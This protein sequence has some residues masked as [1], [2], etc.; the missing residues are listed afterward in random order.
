[1]GWEIRTHDVGQA[2]SHLLITPKGS[3][4]LL[5]ADEDRIVNSLDIRTINHFISTHL[6]KDHIAGLRHLND[7]GYSIDQAYQPRAD[8]Y[9]TDIDGGVKTDVLNEYIGN[10]SSQ[11]IE[12]EDINYLT[13]GDEILQEEDATLTALSPPETDEEIETTSQSSGYDCL[14]KPEE[15]NANGTV[16]KFEGPDGVSA[17]FMGDV[18]DE[19]AHNAESWLVDQHNDPDSDVDLDADILFI[20]HHGSNKSSDEKFLDAVDPEDVV[21]SSSSNNNYTSENHHDG[22]PHDETLKRLHEHEIDVHWTAVHGTTSITVEDGTV[23]L[24]YDTNLETTAAADIGALKY[25]AR[26]HNF[27]QL[28]TIDTIAPEHLPEETPDWITDAAPTIA[29]TPKEM[30]AAT[31]TMVDA[32]ITNAD[33]VEDVRQTLATLDTPER[34]T[35]TEPSEDDV[36]QDRYFSSKDLEETEGTTITIS[37]DDDIGMTIDDG[38]ITLSLGDSQTATDSTTVAVAA[39]APID[40]PPTEGDSWKLHVADEGSTV[41]VDASPGEE[42]G[43]SFDEGAITLTFGDDGELH[44]S[45][46][47]DDFTMS[48]ED[49][50]LTLSTGEPDAR[51]PS[52]ERATDR[53]PD[54]PTNDQD[55]TPTIKSP[56]SREG[57]AEHEPTERELGQDESEIHGNRTASNGHTRDSDRDSATDTS[58]ADGQA[59]ASKDAE[60]DPQVR[61]EKWI[62]DPDEPMPP[63]NPEAYK[64]VHGE[65][66]SDELLEQDN[67]RAI[68]HNGPD[69]DDEPAQASEA[70]QDVESDRSRERSLERKPDSR[71]DGG[72]SW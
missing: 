51:M 39:D 63:I 9:D 56:P 18:G 43:A 47:T 71:D 40:V 37:S 5:D 3:T 65:E 59:D 4:V 31:Q 42:M 22:H 8:R 21:I 53:S 11:G 7:A 16:C 28:S 19:S 64:R 25:Y 68:D 33:T 26:A 10:L 6:H 50:D 2:D 35:A 60:V 45:P 12:I 17:L 1:M 57:A 13:I 23:T 27:D 58:T 55:P 48:R 38:D 52:Q 62:K 30:D 67:Q 72:L 61:Y 69:H 34:S 29:D 36:K 54:D 15:A 66:P 49:G 20:G 70:D 24:D 32:A 41:T 44:V 46:A 14:F